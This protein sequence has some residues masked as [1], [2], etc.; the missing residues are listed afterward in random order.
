VTAHDERPARSRWRRTTVVAAVAIAGIGIAIAVGAFVVLG[1]PPAAGAAGP[2]PRFD[3]VTATSGVT[4]TYGGPFVYAVGGGVTVFDCDM[5]GRPDLY[6]A[7]GQHP[8]ALF[9]NAS[10]PGS[11]RFA[12]SAAPAAELADV[13][14]A[15]AIDVDSDGLPDLVL[16]RNG[17]NVVLRNVG[18][19]AFERANEPWGLVGGG[20][21]TEAFSATWEIGQSWPTL[22]FGNYAD[23][24]SQDFD[25]WCQPNQLV[26]PADAAGTPAFGPPLA[27]TPSFCALSMLFTDWDGSGRRDLR[28]SNDVHYYRRD[29]GGE[30]LWQV[31]PGGTPRLYTAADGWA[32]VH[33]EGMGIATYDLDG[34]RRPEVYLTSQAASKLQTLGTGVAAGS[35]AYVDIGLARGVNVAHP[36]MGADMDLPS[37]AWH[38][39][40]AD[41]NDDGLVDLFVS[42]GNVT[43]QPDYAIE[44]PS[45]LLLGQ[46]DGTFREAADVAG[47]V[48]W[49]RGR[50]AALVDLDLDG[51]LDLVEA[52]YDAPVRIWRNTGPADPQAAG[53]AHWLALR[54]AQPAPNVDA[55]GGWLEVRAG[56]T[57]WRRELTIGGGHA[58]GQL[59]WVHVGLGA[60]T[61]AEVRVVW[62][63]G[64]VGP[65]LP[66]SADAFAQIDRGAS[67]VRP[68]APAAP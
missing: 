25:T 11:I 6:L 17:E 54:V 40:F 7:G 37:T 55:I 2:P 33:V 58:G 14:G 66:V 63:D 39:E 12:R 13:N 27:L 24:E 50:G 48:T 51:R 57:I 8:A 4:H 21:L 15:Y 19:C 38:P 3:D 5:D 36:F 62:P 18:G 64:E 67:A 22:A 29:V 32:T 68:W 26:R 65:W 35:P 10:T 34:D 45:N 59:G 56:E 53:R 9:R 61:S 28:V 20:E 31:P 1:G 49:D 47:I 42:K 43:A 60:A 23:P 44:D 52:F 41:V 16:L 30:Q 46:P